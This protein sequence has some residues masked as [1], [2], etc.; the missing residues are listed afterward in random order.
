MLTSLKD[1]TEK[2]ECPE[3]L[4]HLKRFQGAAEFAEVFDGGEVV[5]KKMEEI[6]DEVGSLIIT[7]LGK[8]VSDMFT[9]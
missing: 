9:D 5:L 7:R 6:F 4:R 3:V 8:K 2:T 1:F